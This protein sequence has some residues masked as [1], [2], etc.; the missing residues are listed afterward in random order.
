MMGYGMD[1]E[2]QLTTR[3]RV[4]LAFR[5]FMLGQPN[6]TFFLVLVFAALFFSL[7]RL[8]QNFADP[9]PF[10]YRESVVAPLDSTL[11]SGEE[12]VYDIQLD[13]VEPPVMLIVARVWWSESEQVTAISDAAPTWVVYKDAV[14]IEAQRRVE[15]P[16]LPAG[17]YEYRVGAQTLQSEAAAYVVPFTIEQSCEE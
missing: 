9:P 16:P 17:E 10:H 5:Q 8:S 14:E 4:W 2:P 15:V 3:Q 1:M 6:A 7:S 12:L 11:C 13:V